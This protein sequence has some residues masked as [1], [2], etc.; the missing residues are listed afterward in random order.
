VLTLTPTLQASA[1]NDPD[2]GDSHAASQWIVRQ[3]A[4]NVVVFDSG[5]DMANL[6]ARMV[7]SGALGYG[8]NYRWQ[9]RFEDNRGLWSDA[10]T[11]TIFS[12]AIPPSPTLATVVQGSALVL[13]WPTNAADFFLEWTTN[14]LP[15]TNWL[16]ASPSPVIVDG[17]NFVTNNLDGDKK[18]YRLRLAQP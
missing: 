14:S 13:F 7:P 16:P 9:V 17:F 6:A 12:T 18:F 8:M 1:F 4:D 10:S 5:T 11:A 2:T 15:A 3:A